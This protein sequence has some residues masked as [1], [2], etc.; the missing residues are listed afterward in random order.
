MTGG[1]WAELTGLQDPELCRLAKLLPSTVLSSRADST[2]AKY[3]YAF[4]RWKTWAEHRT[5]V[6]VFPVSK[7]HLALYLQHLGES[8]HSWSAVQEAVNA[9][10][11]VNHLSGR[12]PI[13]QTPLVHATV[14][15]LKRSLA[16]L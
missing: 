12:E 11:W 7:V 1:V 9:I 4:Q 3:G 10:G 6:S 14:A 15:G 13:A 2:V 16:K 8:T 5:G